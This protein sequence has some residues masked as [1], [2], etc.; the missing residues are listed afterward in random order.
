[1]KEYSIGAYHT[2]KV[3]KWYIVEAE[4]EEEAIQ[5]LKDRDYVDRIEEEVQGKIGDDLT[6]KIFDVTDI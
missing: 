6:Y 2:T 4:S 5:K 1:M 3:F